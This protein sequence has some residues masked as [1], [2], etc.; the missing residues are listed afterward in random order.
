MRRLLALAAA[1][2]GIACAPGAQAGGASRFSELVFAVTD[3]AAGSPSTSI[4]A[5]D[6]ASGKR[7]LLYRDADEQV[8]ILSSVTGAGV[9]QAARIIPPSDAAVVLRQ[10]PAESLAECPAA[11]TRLRHIVGEGTPAADPLFPLHMLADGGYAFGERG[12]GPIFAVSAGGERIAVFSADPA[13]SA[14]ENQAIWILSGSGSREW[15]IPLEG[16]S[17]QVAD[18]AWSPDGRLLAYLVLPR[19]GPGRG[20]APTLEPGLYLADTVRKTK[21][22]VYPCYAH[23]LAWGPG[24]RRITLA[25]LPRDPQRS[26]MRVLQ[27]IAL[28]SGKKTEEISV[29]GRVSALAY[30]DG[31]RRLA[32]Q[33]EDADHQRIWLFRPT[34]GWGWGREIC[35]LAREEGRLS[36]LGWARRAEAKAG[37]E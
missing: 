37:A 2:L 29:R 19:D 24:P 22:L 5:L 12:L 36:L 1:L 10:T 33:A 7:R 9:T 18:L 26:S 34:R 30:S 16:P 13:A 17:P 3:T 4:Y 11:L 28:P 35:D 15:M 8:H 20:E 32:V 27:I 25:S 21:R 6:I 23:V 31:Y 14:P